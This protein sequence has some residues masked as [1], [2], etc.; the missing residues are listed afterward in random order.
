MFN[1]LNEY[2]DHRLYRNVTN[3]NIDSIIHISF[4]TCSFEHDLL[5][6][7]AIER[8]VHIY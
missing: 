7:I 8:G 5:V 1:M 6:Y 4:P 2:C 3:D